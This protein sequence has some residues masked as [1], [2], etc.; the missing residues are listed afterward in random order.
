MKVKVSIDRPIG[1]KHPTYHYIYPIN[2]GYVKEWIAGDGEYQDVYVLDEKLPID[3]Y[4]GEV[5]AIIHRK[6][7]VEDKW[8]VANRKYTKEE[9]YQAVYFQEQYFTIEIEM[10]I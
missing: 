5:I 3:M 8:V 2:Y 4:I 7:D 10:L 9:I 1:S 6:D